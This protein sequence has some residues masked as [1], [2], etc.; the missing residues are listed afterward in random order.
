MFK[1]LVVG[2]K[3]VVPDE[4]GERIVKVVQG[5]TKDYLLVSGWR[6]TRGS[7]MALGTKIKPALRLVTMED[8]EK[9]ALNGQL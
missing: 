5:L 6:Y 8:L 3:V 9:E 7:G 4:H 1:G 2:D